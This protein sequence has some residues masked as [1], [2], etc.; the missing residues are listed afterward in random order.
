MDSD[1][2]GITKKVDKMDKDISRELEHLPL[3]QNVISIIENLQKN[4]IQ[5]NNK[6]WWN[7]SYK[8][9]ED[10]KI[11]ESKCEDM[12]LQNGI[13]YNFNWKNSEYYQEYNRYYEEWSEG[14]EGSGS[15]RQVICSKDSKIPLVVLEYSG[16]HCSCNESVDSFENPNFVYKFSTWVELQALNITDEFKKYKIGSKQMEDFI[17]NVDIEGKTEEYRSAFYLLDII[18]SIHTLSSITVFE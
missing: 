14:Y 11:L 6:E 7:L 9:L 18:N 10:Q 12:C 1:S 3:H 17:D 16:S 2:S 5:I 4:Y 13:N 15:S 8:N